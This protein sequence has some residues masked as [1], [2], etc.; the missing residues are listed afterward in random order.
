[1]V[2]FSPPVFAYFS[3]PATTH[4]YT[5]GFHF[6]PYPKC[7]FLSLKAFFCNHLFSSFY[8]KIFLLQNY[9]KFYKKFPSTSAQIYAFLSSTHQ[10]RLIFLKNYGTFK[11]FD[12]SIFRISHTIYFSCHRSPR[13]TTI[14]NERSRYY[15]KTIT[16][17]S[18]KHLPIRERTSSPAGRQDIYSQKIDQLLSDS[19]PYAELLT[20]YSKNF[21]SNVL[22]TETWKNESFQTNPAHPE[23]LLHKS[24][25]GEK[26]RSKS[27]VIIA[28]ALFMNHIPYRY[29][30]ELNLGEVSL[31]PDFTILHPVT[32]ELY[33]WEHFGLMHN[34]DYRN[35]T[36]QKLK[37]YIENRIYPSE[38]LI[39][40]FES[41]TLPLDSERIQHLIEQFFL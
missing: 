13:K 10:I 9:V 36:S 25:S 1:M 5:L 18:K 23:H 33:Y 34:P 20:G 8:T 21:Q 14:F 41:D 16:S 19:S 35:N 3:H 24:L 17:D 40:T 37:L 28:N 31:Y 38:H 30:C 2:N 29:E 32:H 22:T 6:L 4:F 12:F 7:R 39:T 26:L 15:D 11:L 27:E